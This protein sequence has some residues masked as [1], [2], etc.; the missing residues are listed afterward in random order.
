MSSD[1]RRV[2]EKRMQIEVCYQKKSFT[3]L[4]I[5]FSIEPIR[6]N[7]QVHAIS[8]LFF[9]LISNLIFLIS[10]LRWM[11]CFWCIEIL[12]IHFWI[13]ADSQLCWQK[14]KWIIEPEIES[15]LYFNKGADWWK[16]PVD[17][18]RYVFRISKLVILTQY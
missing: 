18:T 10:N 3:H 12:T 2:T 4:F 17:D 7:S 14:N 11:L 13:E 1:T 8:S 9:F 6:L 16:I 15:R 5:Y